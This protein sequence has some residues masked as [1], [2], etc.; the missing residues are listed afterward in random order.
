MG[1]IK[2]AAG[3]VVSSGGAV[4]KRVGTIVVEGVK[5]RLDKDPKDDKDSAEGDAESD[6]MVRQMSEMT[7]LE[8]QMKRESAEDNIL[9]DIDIDATPSWNNRKNLRDE[10]EGLEGDEDIMREK[11]LECMFASF[12]V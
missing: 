1:T 8:D 9:D 10:P 7:I 4:G 2:S 3:K 12:R 11:T 5:N 6:E